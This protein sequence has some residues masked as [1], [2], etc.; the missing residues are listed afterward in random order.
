MRI[1]MAII[2]RPRASMPAR[3][4]GLEH[5]EGRRA[6]PSSS[7]TTKVLSTPSVTLLIPMLTRTAM[8]TTNSVPAV[9][10]ARRAA[11]RWQWRLARLERLGGRR[12]PSRYSPLSRG[13]SRL[14]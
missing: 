1:M 3:H 8:P 11:S 6:I 10:R 14:R 9:W 4:R 12:L 7:A 2:M 5:P 13:A